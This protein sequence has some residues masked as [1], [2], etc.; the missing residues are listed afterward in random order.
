LAAATASAQTVVTW[1]GGFPNDRFS[2]GSNWAGGAPPL[3][4]GTETLQF[5]DNS[6][7]YLYLD[8]PADFNGISLL[9]TGDYNGV[10]A[11][12]QGRHA[13]TLGAG[14]ITTSGGC[15]SYFSITFDVPLV[16]S[17]DQTWDE[18]GVA[19]VS[20]TA[21]RSISGAYAL[22]L[23]GDGNFE[24]LT[25]NS[26][27][28]TFTG[29]V[30]VAGTNS[31]L[32][33][34]ASSSGP[35]G[36]PTHGPLGT[37]PLTLGDGTTFATSTGS[38]ITIANPVTIGDGTT[39]CPVTLGN[40]ANQPVTAP[41][42]L[43]LTG[44]ATLVG[45][46]D[47]ELAIDIG[48][49]STVTFAGDLTASTP[50]LWLDLSGGMNGNSVAIIQGSL[51]NVTGAALN[52]S[53]S[54]ILDGAGPSQVAGLVDGIATGP[55][56][57]LGLGS[58]YAATGGV[59]AFLGYLRTT[60]SDT[61]FEGTL[62]FDTTSGAPAVFNDPIDLSNFAH[63]GSF[64]GLGS[65]TTAIL[66]PSAVITPPAGGNTYFFGGG[67]GTLTVQSPLQD[68]TEM[69][70]TNLSLNPGN[71]PLTLILSGA[72]SYTGSTSVSGAA[73][74]FDTAL[75]SGSLNLSGGYVGVTANSG[76]S[77]ANG[78]IQ[79]FVGAFNSESS[80]VIGFDSLTGTATVTSNIAMPCGAS[81]LFLGTATSVDYAGTI[82]PAGGQYQFSGV[83]G[84]Q[85]TVSSTLGDQCDTPYSV[86][87]GL[88]SPIESVNPATGQMSVSSVTLAGDNSY[89]GGTILN[90]GYLYVTNGNSLGYGGLTVP[91]GGGGGWSGT[92]AV[93]PSADGPVSLQSNIQVGYGG[94]ALNTGGSSTLT[95]TGTISD[96][97]ESSG[98]LGI[99][100]PVDLEGANT[101]SGG[102][103]INTSGA[104][105]TIGQDSGLGTGEVNAMNSTLVF[106]SPSPVL[107]G[108]T[109]SNSTATFAGS[110]VLDELRM[111]ESTLTFNGAAATIDG[112]HSDAQRSGNVIALGDGTALTICTGEDEDDNSPSFHGTITGP[113]GSL[114]VT[115]GGTV[116]LR[117][118]NTY[119][120]GTTLSGQTLII[121]SNNSAV[122]S[123]PVTINSGSGVITNT[124]ITLTN[125]ITLNDGGGLGGYG[126]F[127]PGGMLTFANTSVIDPGSAGLGNNGPVPPT[128]GKLSFGGGTSITFGPGGIYY[129]SISDANGAPGTGYSTIDLAAG[130]GTLN[131]TSTAEAPF[132]IQL[133]SFD[134]ST[135]LSAPVP[136]FNPTQSYSWTLVSAA[137]ITG[138]FDPTYFTVDASSYFLNSTGTGNFFVSESGNDL[139]LNFTPVPEPSTWVLMA[140]GLW[141]IGAA[142]RRRRR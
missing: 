42:I 97:S 105:V 56:T 29:G 25:L 32:A 58:G 40:P 78:N 75:P 13:L 36:A 109:I 66:G 124:G 116:D 49:D 57:Y 62:G 72:L 114:T 106:A 85:V 3:N 51:T 59:T 38:P 61:W 113:S 63:D 115:G 102:T 16:L 52:N 9:D 126:T 64:V 95:L 140:G 19:Y 22:T 103:V 20:I 142:I 98:R 30:T 70:Y 137:S 7:T 89:S 50:S 2:V 99:F 53:L 24:T 37:G 28:S 6:D 76:F 69:S 87:I 94:L 4:D 39:G 121:A 101:Y 11:V 133:Y 120:G 84:G 26:R 65:A 93:S 125:P 128:P 110:P 33:V 122:G 104:T 55:S 77:D 80:G 134:P 141:A 100:G 127:S 91:S 131:L 44:P 79:A 31:I 1:G 71:A 139:M 123:G 138:T 43:T 48:S 111:T 88:P 14:G 81:G 12:I 119:G 68:V 15:G 73:L 132:T 108:L 41:S 136:S 112:L 35:A 23:D 34:G 47:P 82:T 54:V 46:T 92:L 74:I 118:N 5:T 45:H 10:E 27:H 67:G 129:F 135:N 60:D 17:A 96:L 90:S 86:V 117:G 83:K 130:G 21:N 8:T 18:M 107:N